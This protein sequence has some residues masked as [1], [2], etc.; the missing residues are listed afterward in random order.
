MDS[1]VSYMHLYTSFTCLRSERL[2]YSHLTEEEI[3]QELAKF[4]PDQKNIAYR[5]AM[6]DFAFN[7]IK[8]ARCELSIEGEDDY[9]EAIYGYLVAFDCLFIEEQAIEAEFESFEGDAVAFFKLYEEQ[10]T[11]GLRFKDAKRLKTRF[12]FTFNDKHESK[13]L[14]RKLLQHDFDISFKVNDLNPYLVEAVTVSVYKQDSTYLLYQETEEGKILVAILD[15]ELFTKAENGASFRSGNTLV[16]DAL[17][18]K[19][20]IFNCF[21]QKKLTVGTIVYSRFFP[22]EHRIVFGLSPEVK[23]KETNK[24]SS[25]YEVKLKPGVY[26]TERQAFILGMCSLEKNNVFG[27]FVIGITTFEFEN[28]DEEIL[29]DELPRYKAAWNWFKS[30]R[31]VSQFM[32]FKDS[33]SYEENG[34]NIVE[35]IKSTLSEVHISKSFP[36]CQRQDLVMSTVQ[37]NGD[38]YPIP[39]HSMARFVE[40]MLVVEH[41]LEF[42]P[43]PELIKRINS[44][45]WRLASIEECVDY[46]LPTAGDILISDTDDLALALKNGALITVLYKNYSAC[47]TN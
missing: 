45:T 25:C 28:L 18:T 17:D 31:P 4:W 37:I 6:I 40:R 11:S 3:K 44:Q 46:C 23:G 2:V 24:R 36:V 47:Y 34:L 22:E 12:I 9:G 20:R 38:T 29:Q 42:N 15:G 5:E 39:N 10:V 41:K 33:S 30:H 26:Y 1:L 16:Y 14:Y 7:L 21:T 13:V 8:K 32:C 43:L 27:S 19:S 35:H